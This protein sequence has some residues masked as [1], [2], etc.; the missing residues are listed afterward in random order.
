MQSVTASHLC[1]S[2]LIFL[3]L[4]F[5]S[6]KKKKKKRFKQVNHFTLN[7]LF[8]RRALGQQHTGVLSFRGFF[9]QID[10]LNRLS[11]SIS[12]DKEHNWQFSA[13]YI[14]Y[15]KFYYIELT[16][17]NIINHKETIQIFFIVWLKSTN[18][19][20]SHINL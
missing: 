18:H 20:Y 1:V 5:I 11:S 15:Y 10:Q 9:L 8:H 12:V 7:W 3:F 13:S 6:K 4:F 17:W 2:H 14:K 16:N 19:I